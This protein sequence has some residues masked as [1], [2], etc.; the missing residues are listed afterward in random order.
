MLVIGIG[1]LVASLLSDVIG[2]GDNPGFGIQQTMGIAVGVALTALGLFLTL[3]KSSNKIASIILLLI[4][5]GLL[6][7]ALL[8]DVIGIGD[9]P[10]FGRQQTM[11][12][13][14]GALVTA[15]GLF[16]T[17]KKTQD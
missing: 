7:A 16:L 5:I 11:G 15:V 6:I 12:T 14:A 8:S 9:N 3:K 13:I 1:L 10:D 17:V 2:I 4:G